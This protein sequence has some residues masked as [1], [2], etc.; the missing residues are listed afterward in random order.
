MGFISSKSRF[1]LQT[2]VRSVKYSDCVIKC[3]QTLFYQFS[4]DKEVANLIVSTLINHGF[5]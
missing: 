3:T 1:D 4:L 2:K 5:L